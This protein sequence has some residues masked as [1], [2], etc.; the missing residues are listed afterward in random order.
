[1]VRRFAVLALVV[2]VGAAPAAADI[3]A[4]NCAG[5]AGHVAHAAAASH[6][7]AHVSHQHHATIDTALPVGTAVVRGV[8][9]T[10]ASQDAFVTQSRE[11]LRVAL[12]RPVPLAVEV[13]S[14]VPVVR[15]VF[16][17]TAV[18]DRHGPPGPAHTISPLR[19]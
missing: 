5:K 6:L 11:P 3:C 8:P 12:D 2:I 17:A 18:D 10:C 4:A 13:S 19:I 14:F 1:M 16:R 7:D 15:T 9:H